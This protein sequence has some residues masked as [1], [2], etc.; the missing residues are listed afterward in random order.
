MEVELYCL[1]YGSVFELVQN[2]EI[3]VFPIWHQDVE[4]KVVNSAFLVAEKQ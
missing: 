2:A 3:G 4:F 1:V